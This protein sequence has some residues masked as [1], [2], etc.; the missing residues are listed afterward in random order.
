MFEKRVLKIIFGTK[1]YELISVR[2]KGHNEELH[3]LYS[4]Y[5]RLN[6]SMT[7]IWVGHG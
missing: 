6:K 3:N 1:R 4:K 7:M 5:I 2:R